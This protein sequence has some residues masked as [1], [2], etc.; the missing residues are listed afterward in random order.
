MR[1]GLHGNRF[2]FNDIRCWM[3]PCSGSGLKAGDTP[4][5]FT[6]IKVKSFY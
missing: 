2:L 6:A 1:T 5:V 4:E 3:F